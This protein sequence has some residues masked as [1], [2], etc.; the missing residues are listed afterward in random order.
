MSHTAQPALTYCMWNTLPHCVNETSF[1]YQLL[2]CSSAVLVLS[3]FAFVIHGW[4]TN[5]HWVPVRCARLWLISRHHLWVT[6]E[7]TCHLC[8]SIFSICLLWDSHISYPLTGHLNQKLCHTATVCEF[9]LPFFFWLKYALKSF[10]QR[11]QWL[12]FI[13]RPGSSTDIFP[14]QVFKQA[15]TFQPIRGG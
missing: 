11:L 2:I 3:H 4:F 13:D 1:S 7:Q 10:W 14:S 8:H 5:L 9:F 12:R 6:E 15:L